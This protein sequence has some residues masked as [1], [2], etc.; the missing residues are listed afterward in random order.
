MR[1][2]APVVIAL[3]ALLE[4]CSPNSPAISQAG[5]NQQAAVTPGGTPSPYKTERE[6]QA[7]AVEALGGDADAAFGLSLY[8]TGE[9]FDRARN[10]YWLQ[11]AAEN[12]NANALYYFGTRLLAS[13]DSCRIM[14]GIYF[15]EL[16]TKLDPGSQPYDAASLRSQINSASERIQKMPSADCLRADAILDPMK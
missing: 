4:G 11:I 5:S 16:I 1:Q 3:S 6:A 9:P 10:S 8:Y 15:L 2:L 12:R 7:A 13:D 14:R